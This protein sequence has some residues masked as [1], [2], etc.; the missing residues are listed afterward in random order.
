MRHKKFALI[1]LASG[2][3]TSFDLLV[4][5]DN[6][7]W[8]TGTGI[9]DNGQIVKFEIEIDALSKLGQ[10]DTFYIYLPAMNGY[11]SGGPLTGG[12]ITIH[13]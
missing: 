11:G 13:R 3:A 7:A 9:T 8:F 4:I 5:E 10:P 1:D 12:N 2:K 6:R